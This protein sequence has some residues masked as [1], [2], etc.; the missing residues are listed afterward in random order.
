MISR[1]AFQM[2]VG[3]SGSS[4]GPS[5]RAS[6]RRSGGTAGQYVAMSQAKNSS[7]CGGFP[8]GQL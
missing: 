7:H 3:T 5:G 8:M 4:S 2:S 6:N 1:A